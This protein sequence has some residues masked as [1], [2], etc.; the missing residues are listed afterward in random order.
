MFMTSVVRTATTFSLLGLLLITAG[1]SKGNPTGTVSGTVTVKGKA[2]TDASVMF[3]SL[4]TGHGAGGDIDGS[5]KYKLSD[6]I[7]VGQ[8]TAYFAPKSIPPDQGT[9]APVPVHMDKAVAQK[10]WSESSSD[11]KFDVKEGPND[12][13]I[14]IK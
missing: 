14:E 9:A 4:T 5:G 12:I 3:V 7:P 13:A 1:C 2:Y 10:Y 8:Y 6:P 11:L